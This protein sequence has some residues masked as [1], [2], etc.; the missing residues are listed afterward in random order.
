MI[1][2][3]TEGSGEIGDQLFEQG[4]RLPVGA[5]IVGHVAETG[6]PFVTN[7]VDD[8]VFFMRNPLLPETQSEL[9]VPIKIENEMV[10]VLDIHQVRPGLLTHARYA[11]DDHRCRPVGSGLAASE[12]LY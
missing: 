7:N 3:P 9:T 11:V 4:Y 2:W 1:S 6:Q 8:I 5:G 12:T 10:G